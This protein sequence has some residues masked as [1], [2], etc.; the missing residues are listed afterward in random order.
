MLELPHAV[1]RNRDEKTSHRAR[2]G[3]RFRF[4]SRLGPVSHEAGASCGGVPSGRR[5]RHL[6]AA[7]LAEAHRALGKARRR[8]E[9]R[10]RRGQHRHRDRGE[11]RARRPHPHH[12]VFLVREQPRAL[13]E[14]AFRHQQGFHSRHP[15][16]D[17]SGGGDREPF[18]A[19]K[20][21]RR[22]DRVRPRASGSRQVRLLR[23]RHAGA[24]RGRADDAAHRNPHDPRALQ[25]DR[26]GDDRDAR[27]RNRDHLRGGALRHAA[28]QERPPESPRGRQPQPLSRAARGSDHGG[29]RTQ[30]VRDRLLVRGAGARGNPPAHRRSRAARDRR[31]RQRAG[32]Q[33]EP[34]CP[35]LD[36]RGQHSRGAHRA[37]PARIRALVE[38]GQG[39]RR[40]GGMRRIVR[41][42]NLPRRG[43]ALRSRRK[44]M[45]FSKF[46]TVKVEVAHDIAWVTMNRPDKRNAMSPQMHEEMIAALSQLAAAPEAKVLVLAGAGESWSAGQD[47]QLF[48]R[49]LDDKPADKRRAIL[50]SQEW[51]WNQLAHFPKPTIAMVNGFCYGA[52]FTPLVACDFA[53]AAEDAKFGLSEIN[54]G[55]LPGGLV[56]KVMLDAC[57]YRDAKWYALTGEPF[58]GKVAAR[59][60][61]VNFAVPRAKLTE[62]TVKLA[63]MLL[64]KNPQVYKSVKEVMHHVRGMDVEQ[65]TDYLKAKEMEMRFLDREQ[66]RTQGMKQF[67]DDKTYRPGFETYKRD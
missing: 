65:A 19:G 51:R 8:R 40:Q 43:D 52:A 15:G 5:R 62:E 50:A 24:P 47:I 6:G 46:Q 13:P 61:L 35:G 4:P 22:A 2:A 26:S 11:E 9:P 48:F 57:S 20:E 14:P 10:G 27:R 17:G 34:A 53:I 32:D 33:G 39:G 25:G 21:P 30:G 45:D 16:G 54:W 37:H 23:D 36:R 31:D 3:R 59:I 7:R 66:G 38:G 55:I 63:K 18:A 1:L 41:C 42:Y 67:L 29:S 44:K 58:D 49:D 28:F 60:R 56:A 12:G 64:T